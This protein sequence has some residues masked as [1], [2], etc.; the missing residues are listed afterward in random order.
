[1]ALA[2]VNANVD[3]LAAKLNTSPR[4]IVKAAKRLGIKLGAQTPSAKRTIRV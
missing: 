1:M 4:A 3:K 2:R